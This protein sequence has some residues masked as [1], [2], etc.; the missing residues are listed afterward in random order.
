LLQPGAIPEP[1]TWVMM[2]LGLGA[3][4]AGLRRREQAR[5]SA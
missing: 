5:A 3:V 1:Q 4:G 2:I